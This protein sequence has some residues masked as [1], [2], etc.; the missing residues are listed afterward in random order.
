M[1]SVANFL[2]DLASHLIVKLLPL[3]RD[4]PLSEC[5]LALT[6]QLLK[7]LVDEN[8]AFFE[9]HQLWKQ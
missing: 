8:L 6:L 3:V 9:I 2:F 7:L 1:L 5:V 4:V